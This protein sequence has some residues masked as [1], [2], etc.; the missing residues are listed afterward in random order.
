MN[1]SRPVIEA[2]GI[3]VPARDEEELLPRCLATLDVAVA[4]LREVRPALQCTVLVV[5]D[6]C[7][8]RSAEFA[9]ACGTATVVV[10]VANVGAARAAGVAN[11]LLRRAGHDPHRHWIATTDADSAVPESWLT[12]QL[13]L[14]ER[15][16]DAVVGTVAVTDWSGRPERV[17]TRWTAIHRPVD[18][19]SHV[20]GA[21]LGVT[22]AAYAAVGGFLP[23]PVGE[24]VALVRALGRGHHVVRTAATPVAT[25]TRRTARAAGGF[26]AYLDGL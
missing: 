10:E 24:D 21:N 2:V 6:A 14:A 12:A 5:L 26:A 22:A 18:G 25:S 23:L 1:A 11:L 13:E 16:A 15:G 4:R 3:V 8:D 9:A 7:T 20:H 17:R 19:H